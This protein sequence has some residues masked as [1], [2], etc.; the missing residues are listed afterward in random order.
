MLSCV[1]GLCPC[2]V[3]LLQCGFVKGSKHGLPNVA[4]VGRSKS[5]V[6]ACEKIKA[7]IHV[8]LQES[9]LPLDEGYLGA[10]M[11]RLHQSISGLPVSRS[12]TSTLC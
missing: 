11:C 8:H 1:Q 12:S 10:V 2:E 5:L 6:K 4:A 7:E 3:L 9:Q